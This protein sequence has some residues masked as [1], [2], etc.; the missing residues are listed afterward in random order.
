[1]RVLLARGRPIDLIYTGF[2]L[3]PAIGDGESFRVEPDVTPGPGD[4]V[5]CGSGGWCDLRRII[6]RL[7]SGELITA[8]DPFPPGREVLP[9][10][11][12]LGVIRRHRSLGGVL[13]ARSFAAWSRVAAA[14]YWVRRILEAPDFG[15]AAP[16]SVME[17]YSQ[18]VNGYS[19]QIAS[20]IHPVAHDLIR[21]HLRPPGRLLV[22]GSGAGGEALRLAREG[23]DV[24][25]FDFVPAMVAAGRRNAAA[26]GVHVRFF[27]AD[28]V[29]LEPCGRFGIVFVTPLVYSFIR[30]RGNRL[31]ALR[32]LGR[33]LEP[34]GAVIYTAQLVGGPLRRLQAFMAWTRHRRLGRAAE[35]GDWYTWFVTP[36]GAIGKSFLRLFSSRE[37][38]DEARA[39]GFR[40][41]ERAGGAHFV[42]R[43]FVE[44]T[45]G[46]TG[47]G[48]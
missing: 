18:Q 4:L 46:R 11:R 45:G 12:I 8:L 32:K 9:P 37:V 29:G 19:E 44:R 27:V 15:D 6:R 1:M 24:S 7:P 42:A 34:D 21:R 10:D 25:G 23:Y 38:L 41:A 2:A 36:R 5:L 14:R 31:R 16:A 43:D 30:G 39:A 26:A 3:E 33:A 28:L 48:S 13:R 47:A 35:L 40:T 17:K 22:A 20:P